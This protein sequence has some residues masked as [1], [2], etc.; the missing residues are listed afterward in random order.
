MF[1]LHHTKLS[2]IISVSVCIYVT[3]VNPE[4]LF[5]TTV[6]AT[7]EYT[8]VIP[9]VCWLTLNCPGARDGHDDLPCIDQVSIVLLCVNVNILY[10]MECRVFI[11]LLSR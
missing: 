4:N 5:L 11:L 3:C 7:G 2:Y 9:P 10:D 1:M 6:D 8:K